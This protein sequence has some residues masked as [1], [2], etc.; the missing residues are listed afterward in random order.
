MREKIEKTGYKPT[1][2]TAKARLGGYPE[3]DFLKKP[4]HL[5]AT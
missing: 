5:C 4:K 2:L 1:A 3:K